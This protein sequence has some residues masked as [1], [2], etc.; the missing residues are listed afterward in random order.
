MQELYTII[1]IPD[2][3]C[4]AEIISL[5][6]NSKLLRLQVMWKYRTVIFQPVT[7]EVH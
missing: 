5:F 3:S 6:K 4:Q 1:S 2:K 7:L